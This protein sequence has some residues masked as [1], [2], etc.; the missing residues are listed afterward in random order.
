MKNSA[1]LGVLSLLVLLAGCTTSR[2]TTTQRETFSRAKSV[3]L[4][5]EVDFATDFQAALKA[6]GR[7]MCMEQPADL[8]VIIRK[9]VAALFG[10]YELS[11][12]GRD[13]TDRVSVRLITGTCYH[14]S[15]TFSA[16]GVRSWRRTFSG[17]LGGNP[18]TLKP[19]PI[20]M[21]MPTAGTDERDTF[22]SMLEK[23]G[24]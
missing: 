6:S 1:K 15:V 10:D 23:I 7:T 5:G 12:D 8:I 21:P 4:T 17:Q 20:P 16:P 22:A 19:K 9:R 11:S 13:P 14:G 2:L 24:P 18:P 3:V